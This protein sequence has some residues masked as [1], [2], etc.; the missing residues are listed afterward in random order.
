MRVAA[1][2]DT[3]KI[4]HAHIVRQPKGGT[5]PILFEVLRNRHV[6]KLA[7]PGFAISRI[8]SITSPCAVS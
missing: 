8:R 3:R 4:Q 7:T 5:V 6:G 1:I 2:A